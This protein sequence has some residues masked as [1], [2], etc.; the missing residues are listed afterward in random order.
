MGYFRGRTPGASLSRKQIDEWRSTQPDWS[1]LNGAVGAANMI[2]SF[3]PKALKMRVPKV[4]LGSLQLTSV[5]VVS[6]PAGTF[7]NWMSRDM[8]APIVGAIVGTVLRAFRVQIDYARGVT[9]LEQTRN[10]AGCGESRFLVT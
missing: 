1:V 7:E 9:Y 10:L 5:G 8:T 3:D 4:A 6:R 2:G